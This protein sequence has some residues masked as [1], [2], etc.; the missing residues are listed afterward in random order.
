MNQ[1]NVNNIKHFEKINKPRQI[2][3]TTLF[4]DLA[5]YFFFEKAIL[6]PCKLSRPWLFHMFGLKIVSSFFTKFLPMFKFT[7]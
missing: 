6:P 1:M 4:K 7:F 3:I 5:Y 2:T